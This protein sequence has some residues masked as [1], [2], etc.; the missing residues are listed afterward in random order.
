M[1]LANIG[2]QCHFCSLND[3]TP[4]ECVNCNE[5]FCLSH[6]LSHQHNCTFQNED[7][8]LVID[9]KITNSKKCSVNNCTISTESKLITCFTCNLTVCITHREPNHHNCISLIPREAKRINNPFLQKP[10]STSTSTQLPK[11]IPKQ[12]NNSINNDKNNRMKAQLAL[13]KMKLKAQGD[14]TLEDTKRYYIEV[15]LP[16]GVF[17]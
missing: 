4:F 6:R 2:K 15:F 11:T 9:N 8:L 14:R 16:A 17:I 7:K 1:E 13:M 3:Y 12:Q 10:T 5:W